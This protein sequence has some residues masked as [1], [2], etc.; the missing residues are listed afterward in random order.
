MN[1]KIG[2]IL[3]ILASLF[4]ASCNDKGDS[5]TVLV[6]S[7]KEVYLRPSKS[8]FSNYSSDAFNETFVVE[9]YEASW[10]FT[11]FPYWISLNPVS[12][13]K[14]ETVVLSATENMSADSARSAIF[15]LKSTENDWEYSCAMSVSQGAAEAHLT[16]D[17]YNL[18]FGGGAETQTI[19]IN[20]NCNWNVTNEISWILVEC[21]NI[22]NI[23]NVSVSPN[24]G[25]TYRTGNFYIE[26]GGRSLNVSV[27]Q[28]PSGIKA[29]VSSLECKNV[30]SAYKLTIEADAEWSTSCSDSWIK[31][32]PSCGLAGKS[33]ITIE[34]TPNANI[35]NRKGYVTFYTGNSSKLQIEIIQEGLYIEADKVLDFSDI[36]GTLHLNVRSNTD[37]QVISA[38][39]WI[40]LSEK[41]G[42]GGATISVIAS[43]NLGS[44]TRNGEIILGQLGLNLSFAVTV[45]QGGKFFAS[46][47]D[48]LNFSDKASSSYYR[49]ISNSEWTS[50]FEGTWYTVSPLRGKGDC[51]IEVS[52]TEN[53]SVT[54]R[55]GTIQYLYADNSAYVNIHQ[56]AKYLTIDNKSFEFSSIGGTHT[57]DICT[58]AKWTAEI[59]HD[60]QWLHISAQL[61]NGDARLVI[62]ADDN[63]SINVRSTVVVIKSEYGQDVRILVS[64]QPKKLA[65]SASDIFFYSNGGFSESITVYT[66]GE[67][68]I[69]SDTDWLEIVKSNN[70][71]FTVFATENKNNGHRVGKITVY[72]THLV[73]CSLSIE[74]P[75]VQ[76]GENCSFIIN[77]YENETDWNHFN[78]G[79]IGITILGYSSDADWGAFSYGGLTL[80]ITGYTTDYDWNL[81]DSSNGRAT[82]VKYC[83]DEDWNYRNEDSSQ[84][85]RNGYADDDDWD[86]NNDTSD[87]IGKNGYAD[88]DDWNE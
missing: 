58:N 17:N 73:D 27:K 54:E 52:V 8:T 48:V 53:N 64:Q 16:V 26:Y 10:E 84:I 19:S 6:P 88:D 7:L 28:A 41:E 75:V 33:H 65:I 81:N 79:E 47:V 23:L 34:V 60:V 15:Y 14:T 74:L 76:A 46:D 5:N 72:L 44:T 39:N 12:G 61:G 45:N 36:G 83:D 86:K 43:E 30:S 20:A 80:N 49:I 11:G 35:N 67:Y 9:S 32:T 22:N 71:T 25:S 18:N 38:P 40:T 2:Y 13:E 69:S 66:D 31:V 87:Q 3:I 68:E 51:D 24:S 4:I 42:S 62:T 82:I 59:E 55:F 29:S 50:T 37:W 78:S 77:G 57:V 21:D 1:I 63:P 70:D 85:A 56:L